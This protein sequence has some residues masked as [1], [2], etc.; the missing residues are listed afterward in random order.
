MLQFPES[1]VKMSEYLQWTH[2]YNE[3]INAGVFFV[4]VGFIIIVIGL[5]LFCIIKNKGFG[6]FL[7]IIG[8][9]LEIGACGIT[10]KAQAKQAK[11]NQ[12]WSDYQLQ[13]EE[14]NDK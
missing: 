11:I 3:Y 5:G 8:L 6:V 1:I 4:F 7:A 9:V 12:M 14:V 2:Y 10:I 13:L